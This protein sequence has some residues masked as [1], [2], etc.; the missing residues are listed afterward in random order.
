MGITLPPFQWLLLGFSE[1]Q[2]QIN[3]TTR[4]CSVGRFRELRS[5]EQAWRKFVQRVL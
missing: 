3:C 1:L 4:S 5:S 2:M